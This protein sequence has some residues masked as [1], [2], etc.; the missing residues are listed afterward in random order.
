LSRTLRRTFIVLSL[1]VAALAWAG[2]ALASSSGIVISEIRFRGPTGGNDE[3][4]E[5]FN[6]ASTAVDISGWRLQGCAGASGIASTRA[7]VPSATVLRPGQHYLFTN[8]SGYSGT[9]AGDRTYSTGIADDGGVR[10][11]TAAGTVVD[12][13]GSVLG[14]FD[15]CREGAGLTFPTANGD[16][17]FERRDEG[18]QDT[19]DNA[20]DFEGPKAGDPE[21][22]GG[23]SDPVVVKIHDIQGSGSDSPRQGETVIV[24]AIVTGYDDEVGV[25]TTSGRTFAQDAG[26]FVQEEPADVDADPNTS[27]GIF[28][29]FVSSRL[30]IPLGSVVRLRGTVDEQF[31]LTMINEASGT[32]PVVVG[33]AA[34]PVPVDISLSQAEAQDEASKLYYESLE[35]MRVRIAT[36]IANSGGTNK[37]G[38]L[39]L[40][41]GTARD[42]VFRTEASPS[43]I[44]TDADAGAGDPDNPL[45][46]PDGSTTIVNGDL[47]DQVADVVGPLAFSFSNFKIMVQADR[48]P[49]VVDGPTAFPYRGLEPAT[50]YQ[51]RVASFNVE[52]FFPVGGDLDFGTVSEAEYEEKKARLADAIDRLL[53]RPKIIAVQEVV[54]ETILRDLAATLGG[55]RAFLVEGNDNRGIDVGFLVH[56]TIPVANVRQL[57]KDAPAPAGEDCSDVE[58]K[59]FDRPPLALDVLGPT[60]VTVFSNHFASKG[61]GSDAC[62]EAQAAFVRDRV[63]ELEAAG[64]EAVVAGDLNAFEDEGALAVF[65]DD[66]TT[67]TNLWEQA[68]EQERYSFAFNGKLQT[69]DHILVTDGLEARV[70]GFQYAHFNNDY[71]ERDPGDGHKVSD[72][73]PPV[74]TLSVPPAGTPI[75]GA[76][77]R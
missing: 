72:H 46:D 44:A 52:N 77:P 10:M 75:G 55:Y 8:S 58:G 3:F 57:G 54:D 25:S 69:L 42:R 28:V 68:P 18:R 43:L 45:R 39:F 61:S 2:T 7:T 64:R 21:N 27:E 56:K 36:A 5:L 13:V 53:Q 9:V 76:G 20:A 17:S 31:G 70:A 71:F 15:E 60:P 32:E 23:P 40:T 41:P 14:S 26:I 11:T 16:N 65:Q 1:S 12:G 47:F 30:S 29:G 49:V 67:L 4:V 63:A 24:E 33:S 6:T 22:L 66:T 50:A 62:R 51:L 37:F 35:G 74:L 59:L 48:L 34:V 19:D 73:D 38:E